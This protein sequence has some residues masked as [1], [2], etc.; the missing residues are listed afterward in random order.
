M[1]PI[2]EMIKTLTGINSPSGDTEEA[3]QFV[4]KYAKDLGY[5]TTLTNKG[6]LLITVPGKN[7][8]VQRCITAHVDTLGAMVKEI[9]EDG[10]LAIELIGGFTYNAI[11]GEYCQIKTDAGQIYTGTICLHETSVHVYRNNHEIPRDQKHM[12]IRIDEVTTSE[13]DTKS[14][15]ISVG[16]FVSFDPRTVIT[17]SGFIKSRHL[18]DKASVAMILQLLKKLKE[19]QIILPHTTQF[20]ISNNEE[21][22]YGANASIDSKIKEYIALDMGALGDGQASDEYTVS[23][24]HIMVQMLQQLYMLVRISDM[25]YLALALN[26]LMQWNEHILI[27]LKRQR[28]YYMHI[29]YHQLSKQLVLTNVNDLCNIMNYKNN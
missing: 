3:I 15:G 12:E 28:N 2:L 26:H 7:D 16:N 10:R 27:L 20:Y 25:V 5:Q 14:L 24:I 19:E 9:K 1:E 13:E 23:I 17:S 29:A 4:E 22:G 18:D 11:E 6:A 21:I 8:E